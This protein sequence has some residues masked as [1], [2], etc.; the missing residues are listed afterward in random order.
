MT[1]FKDIKASLSKTLA[2]RALHGEV[3]CTNLDYDK[4]LVAQFRMRSEE[5]AEKL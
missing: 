1:F 5:P 2:K 3:Q 4:C